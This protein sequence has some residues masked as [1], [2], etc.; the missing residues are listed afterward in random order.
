[1][2]VSFDFNTAKEFCVQHVEKFVFG[3]VILGL[4]V[5]A[6]GATTV[7][8][9]PFEP[10]DL[11]NAAQNAQ[12]YIE[13]TEAQA[14]RDAT[15]FKVT[16]YSERA[17]GIR[18]PIEEDPYKLPTAF[19]KPIY[20]QDLKRGEP[21]VVPVAELRAAADH[22]MFNMS[23][24]SDPTG[25]LS[26]GGSGTKGLR[27]V[28]VTGLLP[29]KEQREAFEEAFRVM[30]D[31]RTD[32]PMYFFYGVERAE[33]SDPADV[34]NPTWTRINPRKSLAMLRFFRSAMGGSQDVH[35]MYMH[36]VARI[37]YID[38]R[39]T[40]PMAFPLPPLRNAVWEGE[41]AHPPE[42]PLAALMLDEDQPGIG[43]E[44]FPGLPGEGA[45]TEGVDGLPPGMADFPD[46]GGL[47]AAGAGGYPGGAGYEEEGGYGGYG[48]Y[49]GGYGGYSED[50]EAAY[51]GGYGYEE[52]GV[53]GPLAEQ[54]EYQLFRFFDFE[55]EQGKRYQY[56]VQVFLANPNFSKDVRY[57]DLPE[58]ADDKYLEAAA[59]D[60][61]EVVV[62][63]RD[64]RLMAGPV[65]PGRITTE[66]VADV[67]AISFKEEDGSE[68]GGDFNVTLGQFANLV[69]T[70]TTRTDDL[71]GYGGY[72]GYEEEGD[73]YS[74]Y[75]DEESYEEYGAPAPRRPSD[76]E[77][78][79]EI[80]HNTEMLVLDIAGGNKLHRTARDLTEPGAL[81]LR[82]PD[83]NLVVRD[84][85][86]DQEDY[87]A[88][89]E[90]EAP[91]PRRRTRDRRTA[92]EEGYGGYPAGE[93]YE[94][95]GEYGGYEEE[96]GRRGRRNRSR[97]SR[98]S[99]E[100]G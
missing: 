43:E 44:G 68:T 21:R 74:G 84:E 16:P 8:G 19:N 58:L 26:M 76:E 40:V 75:P 62:V 47:G 27:Y 69:G 9:R 59:S 87:L 33:I 97:R 78:G 63:P 53:G 83:G 14:Y 50:P 57:L 90:E 1:M 46:F 37:P 99:Y 5:L 94:E 38:P 49:G 77:E 12:N 17:K 92:D 72:G 79:E 56:R 32:V 3:G 95:G 64:S 13:S 25:Q 28:A 34:A 73:E 45:P 66:P 7:P 88:Y 18:T 6:Y 30:Y 52:G 67:V 81:L 22:G 42:I 89:H 39:F 15:D 23:M 51:G 91:L 11:V 86:D 20:E 35:P 29:V 31:P 55:V 93:G 61:T 98:E 54:A 60:P 70:I 80:H 2:K 65:K 71:S 24:P 100:E 36:P 96:G 82:D 10:D 41:I 48:G 4:V 85:L